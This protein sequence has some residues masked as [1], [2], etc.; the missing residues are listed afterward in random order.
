[1]NYESFVKFS[2]KADAI[3]S[4]L[5]IKPTYFKE[6]VPELFPRDL[7]AAVTEGEHVIKYTRFVT[8]V[9]ITRDYY[10]DLVAHEEDMKKFIHHCEQTWRGKLSESLVDRSMGYGPK[11]KL[12][13]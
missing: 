3:V 4:K 9:P 8:W 6:N 10:N 11:G 7:F 2:R 1:M 12:P 5:K 13:A